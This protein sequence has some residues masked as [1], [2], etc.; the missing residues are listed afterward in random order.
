MEKKGK[1]LCQHICLKKEEKE[2]WKEGDINGE[3]RNKEQTDRK[4]A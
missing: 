4:N 2:D 3:R 1:C